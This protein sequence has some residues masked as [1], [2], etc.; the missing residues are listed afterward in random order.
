M[1][2]T[3][4]KGIFSLVALLL[5]SGHGT[6]CETVNDGGYE[7]AKHTSVQMETHTR[8]FY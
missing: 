7:Q 5:I 4:V 6:L 2:K 1:E 3:I 8:V